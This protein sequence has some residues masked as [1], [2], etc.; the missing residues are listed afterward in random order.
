MSYWRAM[1]RRTA[2][3][4]ARRPT[5][6]ERFDPRHNSLN[7]LRLFLALLVIVSHSW[8]IG[9]FGADPSLGDLALGS[10][11]VAGFFAISGFLITSSRLRSS[12]L[13]FLWRRCLR[14]FPGLWVCLV[15]IVVLFV[16]IAIIS[17]GDS[18]GVNGS[19]LARFIFSNGFFV[20]ANEQI[21]STL[22]N[23]PFPNSWDGSLWTLRYEFGCYLLLGLI[24]SI[25]FV[26]R[27][28]QLIAIL[29]AGSVAMT[30][31]ALEFDTQISD[32]VTLAAY[33][34]TY[35]FAGSLLFVYANRVRLDLLTL[36]L[37]VAWLAVAVVTG[38]AAATTAIP[39]AL[40]VMA[41][42][43]TAPFERIGSRNDISYG[44]Y[45]YAFPIQQVLVIL[46]VQRYGVGAFILV[47]IAATLPFAFASWFLVERHALRLKRLSRR[48]LPG[49]PFFSDRHVAAVERRAS[50]AGV[51]LPSAPA[52]SPTADG[53]S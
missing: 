9:G 12:F 38:H 43:A 1:K 14:I 39:L 49:V 31:L 22:Q 10:W 30:V 36:A 11:A 25:G 33:L 32:T 51:P 42:G 24:M 37:A 17:H 41:V 27:R 20:R 8:P 2:P 7:A 50:P 15:A 52:G 44:V 29:F 18:A 34:A 40:V 6:G 19:T 3:S 45:I 21:G 4:S 26:R 53:T 46:G 28:P 16:P 48:S 35:F 47:A 5:L 23:A 13:P